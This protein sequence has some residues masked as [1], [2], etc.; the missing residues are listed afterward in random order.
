MLKEMRFPPR[1]GAGTWNDEWGNKPDTTSAQLGR[2]IQVLQTCK[3]A[4]VL[5]E[6]E[7]QTRFPIGMLLAVFSRL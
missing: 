5:Y 2:Y 3:I 4:K 7:A 6:W 1:N